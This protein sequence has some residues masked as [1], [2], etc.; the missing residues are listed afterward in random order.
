M[1]FSHDEILLHLLL[2][3][4]NLSLRSLILLVKVLPKNI[5]IDVPIVSIQELKIE[6]P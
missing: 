4:L 5:S 3:D 2:L 1:T 6:S